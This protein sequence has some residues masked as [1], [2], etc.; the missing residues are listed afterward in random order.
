MPS[1]AENSSVII[2]PIETVS[3]MRAVEDLQVAAWG[4]AER[5]IVP[6]NQLVAARY[7]GGSLIGA[8]DNE[9][10][11]GF[12]YGFYGHIDGEI[13]HHSHMLAV[14]PEYRGHD[15]GFRLKLAQRDAVLSDGLTDRITWTFDPLQSINA[16]FNFAKLGVLSD[17]YKVSVYGDNSAS[18]LHQ[19]GTDRLFVMWLIESP[20]VLSI[21]NGD[22]R[23]PEEDQDRTIQLLRVSASNSPIS[24]GSAHDVSRA[25]VAS[26]EIPLDINSIEGNDFALARQWRE[27]T[28][29]AFSEALEAGLVVFSYR[30]MSAGCG[31]Y[32]LKRGSLEDVSRSV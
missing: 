6:V 14:R 17:T 31:T 7:V 27:Q 13:V 32:M 29:H 25:A 22:A 2:R 3:E 26:I 4:D 1:L 19:N 23:K 12:T 8:F 15:L 30:V 10:L 11:A 5:D 21:L 16:H 28:R 9:K 18:F 24:D 20:R